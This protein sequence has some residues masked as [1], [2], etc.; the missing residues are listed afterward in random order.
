[1]KPTKLD[2]HHEFTAILV[3]ANIKISE[4]LDL[5]DENVKQLISIISILATN[6]ILNQSYFNQLVLKSDIALVKINK[7]LKNYKK[8]KDNLEDIVQKLLAQKPA[9]STIFQHSGPNQQ[10]DKATHEK[11]HP[12]T[13][14]NP[15]RKILPNN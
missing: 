12:N 13:R 5:A 8:D 9:T 6:G 7:A 11:N 15:H 4:R 10:R 2:P 3:K 1:M 14:L